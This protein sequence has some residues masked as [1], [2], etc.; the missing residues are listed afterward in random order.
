MCLGPSGEVTASLS[1][2]DLPA[3]FLISRHPQQHRGKDSL[4]LPLYK[5][6]G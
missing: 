4:R 2:G 1:L 3:P 5:V 6:E